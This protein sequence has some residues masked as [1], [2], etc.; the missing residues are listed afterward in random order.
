MNYYSKFLL[1]LIL[2]LAA[3]NTTNAPVFFQ[4][5]I[6]ASVAP[7][8]ISK[9]ITLHDVGG[10]HNTMWRAGLYPKTISRVAKVVH[11]NT[12]TVVDTHFITN[13]DES[14][15]KIAYRPRKHDW[16]PTDGQWI[17]IGNY[18]DNNDIQLQMLVMLHSEF[19]VDLWQTAT[20]ADKQN[21]T[22]FWDNYFEQYSSLVSQRAKVA[23]KAG[24]DSI[25]L[26][27]DGSIDLAQNTKYWK[28][29]IESIKAAGFTGQIGLWTG[30]DAQHNWSGIK[31]AENKSSSSQ[32]RNTLSY[33]D[34]VL[35]QT[36][37]ITKNA[38]QRSLRSLKRYNVPLQVMV[39]TPS[40]TT[41]VTADEYIEP[42]TG[43]NN[44]GNS[45]APSRELSLEVQN[46]AYQ[47]VID[48][49]NDPSFD[50]VTGINSWGYHFRDDLYYGYEPGDA[51]YQKSANVR[52][53]PAE[54][55]LAKWYKD[56]D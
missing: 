9:A 44:R 51:D 40:V 31:I 47:A 42:A 20:D 54:Q 55:L 39:I 14:G 2:S 8:K 21:N 38:L 56:W 50:Y 24:V 49:I 15:Y 48:I 18:A 30:L 22:K 3:C 5:S 13:L 28:A 12:V 1:S 37:D 19:G 23:E 52:R 53:K 35:L 45:L 16:T 46:G 27:Y 43:I 7:K 41:G 25:V 32:V 11:A 10:W 4:A 36:Q 17:K 33:F 6:E 29:M 26:G 34:F